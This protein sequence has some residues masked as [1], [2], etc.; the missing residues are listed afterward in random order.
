MSSDGRIVVSA[1]DPAGVGP[2]VA[3]RALADPTV[4]EVAGPVLLVGHAATIRAAA[5]TAAVTLPRTVELIDV[6][7]EPVAPG[8]TGASSGHAATA[9][10]HAALAAIAAGRAEALVTG[11]ISKS[12]LHAAGHP[13][14]GQTE[15]L[16]DLL[17]AG[18][19]RVALAG[20]PLTVVHVSAHRSLRDAIAAV[21]CARVLRT[22]ELADAHGRALGLECP[23]IAVAGLNP[24]AGE[25]GL[26]G[27]E[28]L[29][30]IGP[31]VAAAAAAGIA[32][33]GPSSPD[34]LFGRAL[35]GEVDIVVAMYH[36]QGHI[37]V[38]LVARARAVA[39]SLGLPIVRTAPDHG[40]A[41]AIAGRGGADAGS[42][43][44]AIILAARLLGRRS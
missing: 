20:G 11:P 33:E 10:V 26:L 19:V 3:V 41:P 23:R 35:A 27:H 28:E 22:I 44:A 18:D 4:R 16:A 29:R 24:H 31:A 6:P 32:V 36:D 38:K 13:W 15:M 9:T 2:E 39:L 42:M 43:I 25:G 14:A 21:T 37:P 8:D 7:G 30:E 5:L 1:G 12:A 17:G 34:T 40:A